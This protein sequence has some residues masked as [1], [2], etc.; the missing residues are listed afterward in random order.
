M[1]EF[2]FE[3]KNEKI[4]TYRLITLFIVILNILFFIYSLFDINQRKSAL[5]SLGFILIYTLY[6]FYKSKKERHFFFFDEWIYFLLMLLWVNNYLAA[7][8][9]LVFFLLYTISLQKIIF[10]FDAAV[11]KQKNF[12]WKKHDWNELSN[13]I[14]KDNLLTIDFKSNK[15]IQAEIVSNDINEKEFNAFAKRQLVY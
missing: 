5:I 2:N 9:C 6:R 10:T 7:I 14:L 11:I 15:L 1:Q 8:I 4:K 13:V 12:P 3:I